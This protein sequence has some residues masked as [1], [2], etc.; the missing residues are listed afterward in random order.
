[1]SALRRF[2]LWYGL[3]SKRLLR[4]PAFLA[5]LVLIPLFCAAILFFSRQESGAVTVALYCADET[6]PA[7]HAA[8]QRLLETDSLVRCVPYGDEQQA[9]DAVDHG[10]ADAAW[11]FHADT[12]AQLDRFAR[13]SGAVA[14]TVVEREDNVFLMLAREKLFAALYP[15][16]SFSLFTQFLGDAPGAADYYRS[17]A[18]DQEVLR[19]TTA[20]GDV[21]GEPDH[22]LVA[23]LRGLLTLL[24][25]L[26]G[27]ASAM[28]CY[29]EEQSGS[30]VW[31]SGRRRRLLPVLCHLTAILPTAAAVYIAMALTG[32]LTDPLRELLL[33]A[34]LSVSAAL[35]CELVRCLAGKA[36]CLGALIPLL[37]IAMLVL[38]PVFADLDL[39]HLPGCLFPPFH[40]LRAV[41][42]RAGLPALAV[43]TALLAVVTLP[44]I[45]LRQSH[46]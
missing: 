22:Y 13:G 26:S 45:R 44:V 19:F 27:L 32:I 31:L 43:Y 6:D 3:L 41:F 5:V 36:A 20:R 29:R 34:L 10:R 2:L 12:A 7:A 18:T 1:M 9:R 30:F 39:P 14:V 4:R 33:L 17:G 25:M 15:E 35:F 38:C 40:Y 11:L 24:L 23:P 46:L 8:A 37:M 21:I 42:S 28:Y 16:L